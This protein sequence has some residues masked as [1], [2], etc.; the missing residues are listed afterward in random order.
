MT[1]TRL[2]IPMLLLISATALTLSS[3]SSN[4]ESKIVGKWKLVESSK[5]EEIKQMSDVGMYL[6][7]EF[8]ADNTF[9]MG[10]GSDK[11]GMLDLIKMTG[12]PVVYPG[13]YKLGSGDTVNFSEFKGPDG[14]GFDGKDKARSNITIE[15][16]NMTIKDADGK[17]MK[18]VKVSATTPTGNTTPTTKVEPKPKTPATKTEPKPKVEPMPKKIDDMP[19][20]TK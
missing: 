8:R 15:G 3:C 6:Y 20:K 10:I 19:P 9:D 18:L 5:P 2:R 16:D 14:K 1:T 12:K 7:F 13:K 4:N 11:P 17:T